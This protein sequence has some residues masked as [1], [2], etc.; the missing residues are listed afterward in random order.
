MAAALREWRLR[1]V[2]AA[3]AGRGRDRGGSADRRGIS[4]V[5]FGLARAGGRG[6]CRRGAARLAFRAGVDRDVLDGLLGLAEAGEACPAGPR[7][8]TR[9][10]SARGSCGGFARVAPAPG[11]DERDDEEQHDRRR[12][13]DADDLHCRHV[14]HILTR[15]ARFAARYSFARRGA[16]PCGRHG[17]NGRVIVPRD[18]QRRPRRPRGARVPGSPG[19]RGPHARPRHRLRRDDDAARWR[20]GGRWRS[21]STRSRSKRSRRAP[22]R[23]ARRA[24]PCSAPPTA[25]PVEAVLMT[26]AQPR[27]RLRLDA[28]RL[29]RRVRVLRLRAP[30]P[31][32]RPDGRGDGR[33]G[34]ALRARAARRGP[35]RHQRRLHGH[36]R[37]VPQ[38]RRDAARLPAAQRRGGLRPRG[39][40]DLGV[41]GGRGA[42][43]S[44]GSPRNR[45]SSTSP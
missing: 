5:D 16:F 1:G 11:D 8:G 19:L 13:G 24:R 21:A 45:C 31:A 20:C 23:A 14:C 37:A 15:F 25:Q 9:R 30:R 29:R 26:Y 2:V 7:R 6:D 36:G 33:P 41:D 32:P 40:G 4:P 12:D 22:R 43:A 34:A 18:T 27:H 10:R 42:R 35:A 28:G 17:Y 44:T 38:L 3:G 39:A